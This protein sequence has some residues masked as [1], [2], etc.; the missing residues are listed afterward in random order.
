MMG[1]AHPLPTFEFVVAGPAVSLRASRKSAKRYQ[2]WILI[3]RAAAHWRQHGQPVAVVQGL[4]APG[5]FFVDGE[6]QAALHRR[7]FRMLGHQPGKGAGDGRWLRD[8]YLK[9]G[10]ANYFARLAE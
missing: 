3:V 5:V 8:F 10:R 4:L 6:Q 1:E 9:T 2:E 7:E